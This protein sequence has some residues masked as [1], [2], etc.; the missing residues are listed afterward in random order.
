MINA[1]AKIM[2]SKITAGFFTLFLFAA[3]LSGLAL[4]VNFVLNE[5]EAAPKKIKP[6]TTWSNNT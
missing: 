6:L 2:S 4:E 1:L 5:I 3:I